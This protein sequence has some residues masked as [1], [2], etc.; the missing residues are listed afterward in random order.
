[1]QYHYL[2][3]AI[4]FIDKSHCFIKT[5]TSLTTTTK[6]PDISNSLP[7]PRYRG[8]Y[9]AVSDH[10]HYHHVQ[11]LQYSDRVDNKW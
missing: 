7:A 11:G 8:D 5:T 9:V 6:Y 2:F 4:P 10:Q 3:M 1:M